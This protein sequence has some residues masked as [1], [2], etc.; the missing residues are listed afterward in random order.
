VG[1]AAHP[2]LLILSRRHPERQAKRGVEGS[3]VRDAVAPQ[4][5][6]ETKKM[7]QYDLETDAVLTQLN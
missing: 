7:G 6:M 4:S 2:D 5:L 1:D 3:A